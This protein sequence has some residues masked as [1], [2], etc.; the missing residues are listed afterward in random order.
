MASPKAFSI[1]PSDLKGPTNSVTL[2]TGG[3]A[4]IGLQT[5][6]LLHD[7]CPNN[8]II[9]L[10][11]HQPNPQQAPSSFIN[12]SRVLALQCDLTNWSSQRESFATG[13]QRFGSID[14]VFVNAGIAE[15]KDQ[16]FKDELDEQGKLKEPDRRVYDVDL[17][18]A[19]DTLKL[20]IHYMRK[21]R[22]EKTG[23]NVVLT[24][25]LAGYLASAGA[26][27]Y[28]AAKHGEFATVLLMSNLFLCLYTSYCPLHVVTQ[29]S[30]NWLL[31]LFSP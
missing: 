17:A 31:S 13:F 25:S 14:N 23:G 19:N 27:L 7:I 20:A 24:A 4:G 15:Y 8:K 6:L 10:D 29:E 9:L 30:S 12:S 18:A 21:D 26:P 11:R 2:I 5:A 22:N 1:L 16:I 3:A 28:S